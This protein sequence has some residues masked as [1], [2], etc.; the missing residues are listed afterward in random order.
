[1]LCV[2]LGDVGSSHD[3]VVGG[4]EE[5]EHTT[6]W[7]WGCDLNPEVVKDSWVGNQKRLLQK[8][9]STAAKPPMTGL[10]SFQ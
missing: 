2:C 10:V 6:L 1:V 4:A 3:V 9:N 7:K 8:V 5:G